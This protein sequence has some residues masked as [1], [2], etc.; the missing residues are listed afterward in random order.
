MTGRPFAN[1]ALEQDSGDIDAPSA[2]TGAQL[3]TTR[4]SDV[5]IIEQTDAIQGVV[6]HT[7]LEPPSLTQVRLSMSVYYNNINLEEEPSASVRQPALSQI[8]PPPRAL[9]LTKIPQPVFHALKQD[10]CEV[11]TG[12]GLPEDAEEK[13]KARL[14]MAPAT[15]CLR[16]ILAAF[17]SGS[18]SL[19]Q[20][21]YE[22][23]RRLLPKIDQADVIDTESA[24]WKE[25]E[26]LKVVATVNNAMPEQVTLGLP[27]KPNATSPTN[28][29]KYME[30]TE[31]QFFR[32][33]VVAILAM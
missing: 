13:E 19:Y 20:R 32:S 22:N 3:S 5:P 1:H 28:V 27:P 15:R 12:R 6:E 16:A 10:N 9:T 31:G 4:G 18:P 7:S 8:G 26:Q 25:M 23:Y 14:Q 29:D 17:D 2:V 33:E 30:L 24:T 11:P 21:V